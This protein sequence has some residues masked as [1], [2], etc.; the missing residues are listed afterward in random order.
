M[1]T[2]KDAAINHSKSTKVDK[3]TKVKRSSTQDSILEEKEIQASKLPQETDT[4]CET[5]KDDDKNHSKATKDNEAKEVK[6][7]GEYRTKAKAG[8]TD[9][10]PPQLLVITNDKYLLS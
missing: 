8:N 10:V 2:T 3:T 1:E 5:I 9:K 6:R 7:R 4:A